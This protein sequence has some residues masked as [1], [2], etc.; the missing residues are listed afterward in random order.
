MCEKNTMKSYFPNDAAKS[1]L[2]YAQKQF[3]EGKQNVHF[4]RNN[5]VANEMLN[6]FGEFPHAF[7]LACIMDRQISA[8][9]AWQI[10]Y[11]IKER[12]HGFN[13]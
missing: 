5:D 8:E 12:I 4:I 10:P 7:V 3:D 2:E 13:I 9:N 11:W 1:L 6:P